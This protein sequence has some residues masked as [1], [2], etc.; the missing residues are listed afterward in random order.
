M[1]EHVQS[2]ITDGLAASGVDVLTVQEDHR[3]GYDDSLL[4]DRATQLGRV[5]F[6]R[7]TDLLAEA[8]RRQLDGHE[9]FGLVYAHP[10]QVPLGQCI[11]ELQLLAVCCEP[12]ELINCVE[13]LPLQ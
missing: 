1:D 10:L 7:D 4:L 3:L 13:Y 12:Q 5:M 6:S 11:R 8:R 9:F 2:A